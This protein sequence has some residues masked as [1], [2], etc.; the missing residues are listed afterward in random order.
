[1]FNVFWRNTMPKLVTVIKE[2]LD[3]PA[4]ADQLVSEGL[5][6]R[7]KFSWNKTARQTL[8]SYLEI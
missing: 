6:N 8:K 7:S 4:L 5:K 2:I 3:S 1:M